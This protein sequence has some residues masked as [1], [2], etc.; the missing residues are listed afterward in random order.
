[1]KKCK[2][3]KKKLTA[4]YCWPDT[5]TGWGYLYCENPNC[6]ILKTISQGVA[7]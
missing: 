4:H 7:P 5:Q 3:C 1:M 6:G 2:D